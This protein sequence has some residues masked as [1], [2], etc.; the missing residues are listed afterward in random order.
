MSLLVQL[1]AAR[2]MLFS[3][4]L[5]LYAVSKY[6]QYRRLAAFKGPFSTGWSDLWNAL[7]IVR[8][9][10]HLC[11]LGLNDKYGPVARVGPN[12]LMTASPELLSH[13]NGARS[14]YTRVAW[15]NGGTRFEVGRDHIFSTIDEDTHTKRRAKMA[16]GYSG[17]ENVG[18]EPDIDKCLEELLGL[19]R[20]RYLSTPT[21]STPFDLGRKV[22]YFTLDVISLIGFGKAFGNLKADAD[23]DG[24]I[25]ASEAGMTAVR[26]STAFGLR[27]IFQWPPIERLLGPSEKDKSGFGHMLGTARKMIEQR[28]GKPTEGRSDMLAAFM[29]HG[30]SKED[31]VT[32][33]LLQI[34]AGSDTSA[35][36][37]RSTMLHLVSNP[38]VYKRLQAEIDAAVSSG[39]VPAGPSIVQDSSLRKLPYLQAVVREG[40][41][42]HPP[43]AHAMPKKVPAGGDSFIVEG[44]QYFFPGGTSICYN[45]QALHRRKDI[46]GEDANEFRPERW[47]VEESE[48]NKEKIAEMTRTTEMI[49]GYGKY[50]CLGKPIA[51]LEIS[52]VLFEFLRHFD[53]AVA[54]PE[55]PWVSKNL[56]GIFEQHS[57]WML[58]T[59]RE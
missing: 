2:W 27:P 1:Y 8:N 19:L 50:Q 25:A 33:S 26:I 11:Y 35:T 20:S 23:K 59:E 18:L 9:D 31:L 29:R 22:Q 16:S 57:M 53:W 43:V 54:R 42:I 28:L 34:M 45:V 47:L 51:W 17:K 58:V 30:L 6:R 41:R 21:K 44:K 38:R 39:D 52:K 37:I 3:A 5:V 36:A 7:T 12:D 49:F 32:E 14:P 46:F 13:M 48:A 55:K 40:L 15:M 10:S 56:Y 4:L 24:Y